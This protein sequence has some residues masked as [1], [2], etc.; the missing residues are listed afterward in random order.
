MND[1]SI[2]NYTFIHPEFSWQGK[3]L[4]RQELIELGQS[5][6]VS[7]ED[8]LQHIGQFFSDWLDNSEWISV[9]TS[10]STGTPKTM[11]VKKQNM[12]NSAAA[13]GDF[14]DLPA[15]TTALLCLPATYIAGKLMLVRAMVLGWKLGSV[16]PQSNPFS[17]TDKDYD[18]S[19]L[20]P[21]QVEKS[22]PQ[23]E[24]A[25]KIIVGGGAVSIPLKEKLQQLNTQLYE[26]YGMTETLT[27]IAARPINHTGVKNAPFKVLSGVSISQDNRECL[28]IKAPRV[29]AETIVTND[30]VQLDSDHSFW[31]KG[32]FDNVINSGGIKIQPE[33]VEQILA[34]IISQRFFIHGLKDDSLGQK[35]SLFIEDTPTAEKLQAYHNAIAKLNSLSRYQRPKEIFFIPCFEE[36][37]SGK[38][39]RKKTL[40]KHFYTT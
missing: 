35:V 32:R 29:T 37:H 11:L 22:L 21:F 19:A 27:H 15:G 4:T 8:Y 17:V 33:E 18:F 28:V 6:S 24:H 14:F 10:G 3:Q 40:D 36:T 13:T 20:T 9:Q 23:L 25:R 7:D 5:Y 30:I 16:K 26:T 1:L 38:V 2:P 31:L 39:S 34:S 12:V